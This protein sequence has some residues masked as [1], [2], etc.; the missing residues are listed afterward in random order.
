MRDFSDVLR[1]L[2]VKAV[3]HDDKPMTGTALNK[4]GQPSEKLRRLVRGVETAT[5]REERTAAM[6]LLV[7]QYLKEYDAG[8]FELLDDWHGYVEEYQRA[9]LALEQ[10]TARLG[11]LLVH[12]LMSHEEARVAHESPD[13]IP[14]NRTGQNR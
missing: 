1:F 2:G 13:V 12:T 8:D 7:E 14:L 11:R 10:A 4:D 6:Q 9:Q 3:R 5:T